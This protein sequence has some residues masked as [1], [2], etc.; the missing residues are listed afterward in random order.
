M[1]PEFREMTNNAL[2]KIFSF[3][4]LGA[5]I[6]VGFITGSTLSSMA[7]DIEDNAKTDEFLRIAIAKNETLASTINKDVQVIKVDVAGIS[8]KLEAQGKRQDDIFAA[9]ETLSRAISASGK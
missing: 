3:E 2:L 8:A 1:S 9:I 7:E 4:F 5:L 6:L